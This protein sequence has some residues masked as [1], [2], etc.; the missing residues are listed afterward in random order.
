MNLKHYLSLSLSLTHTHTHY[1][2]FFFCMCFL[3]FSQLNC[4]SKHQKQQQQ[5]GGDGESQNSVI[6]IFPAKNLFFKILPKFKRL[7]QFAFYCFKSFAAICLN[8]I[9][10]LSQC[11][12]ISCRAD[13]AAAGAGS[14]TRDH[15]SPLYSNNLQSNS[16]QKQGF[17]NCNLVSL[18]FKRAPSLDPIPTKSHNN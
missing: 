16:F 18:S 4:F 2:T 11:K 10:P 15:I 7:R 3:S 14:I 9:P 12:V 1:H 6:F 8:F 13:A 5:E 17:F